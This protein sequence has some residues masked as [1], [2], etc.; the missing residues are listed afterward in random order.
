MISVSSYS[1]EILTRILCCI[2]ELLGAFAVPESFGT[3]NI[4]KRH[5]FVNFALIQLDQLL[6]EWVED[7]RQNCDDSAETKQPSTVITF[8]VSEARIKVWRH[9][10]ST[11]FENEI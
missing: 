6:G 11:V 2:R 3:G 1:F 7:N 8:C 10:Q 4:P 9:L 5:I